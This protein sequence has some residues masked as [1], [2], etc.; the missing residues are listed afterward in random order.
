M[1][2]RRSKEKLEVKQQRS[3]AYKYIHKTKYVD[4][5][6]IETVSQIGMPEIIHALTV[7]M[8]AAPDPV[9][10]PYVEHGLVLTDTLG[11]GI[12]QRRILMAFNGGLYYRK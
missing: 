3:A 9:A 1:P 2:N 10:I 6:I 5:V 8:G 12:L 11:K 4:R 7:S